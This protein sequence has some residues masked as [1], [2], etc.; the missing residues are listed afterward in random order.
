[1]PVPSSLAKNPPTLA[2]AK[3]TKGV[4]RDAVK[5]TAKIAHSRLLV[6]AKTPPALKL[7]THPADKLASRDP[8]NKA[9][10]NTKNRGTTSPMT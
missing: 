6:P 9:R 3:L 7:V 1:M 8:V 5:E 2:K 10:G 4:V